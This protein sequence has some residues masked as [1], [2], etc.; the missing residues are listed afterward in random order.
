[1]VLNHVI[2]GD[3]MKLT[4]EIKF[5]IWKFLVILIISDVMSMLSMAGLILLY[6]QL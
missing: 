2:I 5:P 3:E 6:I 4:D 1:M